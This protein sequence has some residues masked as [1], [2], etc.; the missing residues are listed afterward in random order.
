MRGCSDT[1][2][3]QLPYYSPGAY[4]IHVLFS[5]FVF[6]PINGSGRTSGKPQYKRTVFLIR[7]ERQLLQPK[8]LSVES[9]VSM[10]LA[11]CV[12][13]CNLKDLLS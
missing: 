2:N 7:I 4:L 12:M 1:G 5:Q 9:K 3:M 6:F 13:L 11:N 10:L 8:E